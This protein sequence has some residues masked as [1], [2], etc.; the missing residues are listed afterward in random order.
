MAVKPYTVEKEV[1]GKKYTFQFNG[2]SAA[3]RAL[4]NS[5]IQGT[6][7]TSVEKLA[8]YLFQNVVVQPKGLA[9]DDFDNMEEFNAVIGVA[10]EVMTG[11]FRGQEDKGGAK[12]ASKK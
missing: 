8:T 3:L 12:G 1:M 2:I 6:N 7:N 10:R 4:D 5:Y 11:D 9:I